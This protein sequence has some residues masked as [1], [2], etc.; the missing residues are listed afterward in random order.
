MSQV[1]YDKLF[2]RTIVLA[3]VVIL[4]TACSNSNNNSLAASDSLVIQ[5]KS[6]QSGDIIKTV[7]TRDEKAIGKLTDFIEND[8]SKQYQCPQEGVLL[9]YIKGMLVGDVSFNYSDKDCRH[10][11]Q[12][13]GE[14]PK[15]TKMN[16]EAAAFLKGLAEG[17][18]WY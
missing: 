9:F 6:I 15:P 18:S 14:L 2:M 17:K 16:D 5:F 3:A 1:S 4:F 7:S 13:D 10:F 8:E 12:V 11:L